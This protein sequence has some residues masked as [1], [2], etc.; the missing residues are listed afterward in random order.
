MC[1]NP[2]RR[3]NKCLRCGNTLEIS[4]EYK[5]SDGNFFSESIPQLSTP[6][7][8]SDF[9]Y[10]STCGEKSRKNSIFCERCG[11]E[12]NKKRSET[13]MRIEPK[14]DNS[15]NYKIHAQSTSKKRTYFSV[16]AGIVI[17]LLAFV[18][19]GRNDSDGR[20]SNSDTSEG[21]WV[22]KCREV[23]VANPAYQP[24]PDG[25]SIVERL[26]YD[27]S[28]YISEWQCTDQFVRD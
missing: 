9:K 5:S 2:M 10:C 16:T 21:R 12:F 17:L 3:K 11:N 22:E 28:R 4:L 8:Q 6:S 24:A 13:H 14:S 7:W 27:T 1:S 25:I 15:V 26:T 23:R 18:A 20:P 19:F